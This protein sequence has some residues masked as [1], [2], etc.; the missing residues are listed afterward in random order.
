MGAV[1]HMEMHTKLGWEAAYMICICRVIHSNNQ[2]H[3]STL[4]RSPNANALYANMGQ[5][6]TLGSL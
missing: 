5:Q 6:H 3:I 2:Q 1:R 4:A